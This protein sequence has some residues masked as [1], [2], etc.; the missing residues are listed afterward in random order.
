MNKFDVVIGECNKQIVD[1]RIDQSAMLLTES[2]LNFIYLLQSLV[3]E[4]FRNDV[5]G[6]SYRHRFERAKNIIDKKTSAFNAIDSSMVILAAPELI[7]IQLKFVF[8]AHLYNARLDINKTLYDCIQVSF[9][10]F[11]WQMINVFNVQ[12]VN[13]TFNQ[14]VSQTVTDE[15][16]RIYDD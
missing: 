14:N 5:R 13:F 8:D 10:E 12:F 15:S 6:T 11:N 3:L 2:N 7:L 9:N 16:Y 1:D 4:I